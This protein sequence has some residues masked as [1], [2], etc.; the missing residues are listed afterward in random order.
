MGAL[1]ELVLSLFLAWNK[2]SYDR[3]EIPRV[4]MAET[5]D[6]AVSFAQAEA[7]AGTKDE[8]AARLFL[9]LTVWQAVM[10]RTHQP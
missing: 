4:V 7:T 5:D 6:S 10:D 8:T 3:I 2:F 1:C 9:G